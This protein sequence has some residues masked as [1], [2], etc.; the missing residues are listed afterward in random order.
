MK[1][2]NYFA[3]GGFHTSIVTTFSV[4]FDAY[5]SIALPRLREAGCNNNVIVVDSRMLAQAL[6]NDA[7]RPKFAGRRYS[8]VG[9]HC[10][11][12][13]HAKLTL[14]L[15]KASGRLLVSSANMTVAGLA[16]NLEVAGEVKVA[17][18]DMQAAPLLRTAVDYLL[19]FL[20]PGSVARRQVEWAL[21][22]TPWL[23][24]SASAGTVVESQEGTRLAFLP[25]YNV[26][27]IGQ[28]FVEFIGDRAVKRLVVA[29]PSGTTTCARCIVFKNASPESAPR[30]SSSR[31]TPCIQCTLIRGRTH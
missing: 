7:R 10:A 19:K 22:R 15:G 17:E 20:D 29:S 3:A 14:Q 13:F 28:R 25:S 8:V 11:G 4:D 30:C 24:A 21:K 26:K 5:E 6:A 18:D 12:V 23:Q 31:R 1:L 9:A 16:G 27:G 2:F